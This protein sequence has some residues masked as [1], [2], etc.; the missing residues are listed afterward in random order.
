[1]FDWITGFLEETGYLGIA[2]LMFAE[3]VVPPIPSEVIMPLAGFNAA[4]GH[5][6]FGLV[7]VSG[8]AGSVAGALLWYYVGI[9]L[10]RQRLKSWASSHGHWLTLSPDE[11]DRS[12]SW[13]CAYGK[14]AV[15]FG[16]TIPTVRTLISVPAG[17]VAMPVTPFLAYTILGSAIWS[18]LLAYLGYALE[19]Q[20]KAAQAYLNPVSN[21][22]VVLLVMYYIYRVIS[23]R[24]RSKSDKSA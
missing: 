2:L 18:G 14:W 3:N 10:G 1:M 22:V 12:M 16:R 24:R 20:Y 21:A 9:W 23:Y 5:L 17:I 13:F 7:I 6:N 11:L 4:Q 8:A 15:L 19:E